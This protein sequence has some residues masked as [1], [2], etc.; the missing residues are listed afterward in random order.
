MYKT[1]IDIVVQSKYPKILEEFK[2]SFLPTTQKFENLTLHE[3]TGENYGAMEINKILLPILITKDPNRVFGVFN[4][5]LWFAEGWLEDCLEKMKTYEVVSAG[6]V[7]VREKEIFE[8]AIELTKNETGVAVHPYGPNMMW[9]TSVFPKV[10][11][12]DERFAWSIDDLDWALR[13][14]LHGIKAVTSKKI[15]MAHYFGKTLRTKKEI[16]RWNVMSDKGKQQFYEKH[17]YQ[18]YRFIRSEYK[19]Y[20]QYFAKYRDV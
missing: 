8:R 7:V 15:T 14:H 2:S 5:D 16:K 10:G 4:D 3:I 11:V 13:L 20:H 6:Y 1:K 17:G 9:K 18:S 19:H 12:F